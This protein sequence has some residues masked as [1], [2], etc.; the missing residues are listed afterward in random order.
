MINADANIDDKY[1]NVCEVTNWSRKWHL[2]HG[3]RHLT[4]DMTTQ[5]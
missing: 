2:N 3:M 4:K 1:P 5:A